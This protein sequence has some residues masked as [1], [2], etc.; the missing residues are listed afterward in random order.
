MRKALA[1]IIFVLAVCAPLWTQQVTKVAICNWTQ[2]LTTSYKETQAV[3][4]LDGFRTSYQNEIRSVSNDISDMENRKLDA[5]KAGN[6]ALILQLE[7]D[8]NQ[9]KAYLDEYYR[10]K[11]DSYKRQAAKLFTGSIVK[12]ILD[13]VR[14]VAEQD[15]DALVLRSDGNYA[16]V[17]IYNIP[18]IDITQKVIDRIFS[19]A[20]S[21]SGGR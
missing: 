20:K 7:N 6:K 10:I 8:I 11:T 16:D 1:A 2:I 17:I 9:K 14:F 5:D 18:E 13:A 19:L 21:S 4:E 3:R 12:E 15:G